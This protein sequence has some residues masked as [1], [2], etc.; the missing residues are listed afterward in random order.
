M[1]PMAVSRSGGNPFWLAVGFVASVA[2]LLWGW[3]L[4]RSG[5]TGLGTIILAAGLASF[6]AT[7]YF[8]LGWKKFGGVLLQLFNRPSPG[9]KLRGLL[10]IPGN[11]DAPHIDLSLEC[12]YLHYVQS[13]A[14]N[15]RGMREDTVWTAGGRFP[16]V[17]APG[18]AECRFEIALA[19][20][21]PISDAQPLLG[22]EYGP[23]HRWVLVAHAEVPG[24]DL[25]RVFPITVKAP[26]PQAAAPQAPDSPAAARDEGP[27]EIVRPTRQKG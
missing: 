18:R 2:V 4:W 15:D 6:A 24:V 3:R 1:H 25:L 20:G 7:L 14:H 13:K 11:V 21:V 19:A 8:A 17:R 9:G 26:P 22:G 23:G 5:G 12:K 16:L 10:R 27:I